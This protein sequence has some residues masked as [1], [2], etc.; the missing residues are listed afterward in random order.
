MDMADALGS[1]YRRHLWVPEATFQAPLK[2]HS[3]GKAHHSKPI[4]DFSSPYKGF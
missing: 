4:L 1:L 3:A 2:N